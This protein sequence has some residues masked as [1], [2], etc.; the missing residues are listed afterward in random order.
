[1]IYALRIVMHKINN[2]SAPTKE[3]CDTAIQSKRKMI[4]DRPAQILLPTTNR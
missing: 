4:G 3:C 1:L 2:I